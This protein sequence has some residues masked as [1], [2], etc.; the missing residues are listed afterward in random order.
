VITSNIVEKSE[1]AKFVSPVS[2]KNI[3]PFNWYSFKHRFGSGLVTE[4]F[5]LFNLQ[6]GNIIFDPFCGGGTTLIKAKL[7]GY[8]SVGLD[9]SPFSVFLTNILT[10]QY[11]KRRLEK[12]FERI[13]LD[14]RRSSSMPETQLLDKAF[15][16]QTIEYIFSLRESI[17]PLDSKEKN[18]FLFVLLS[19]LDDMSKAK[20]SGGFLRIT[21][22]KKVSKNSFKKAFIIKA[23]KLM[24]EV[25]TYEFDNVNAKA[26]RGDARRYPRIIRQNSY[27]AIVTSPPYPNRH[28]YTRIY[29]LELLVGFINN[30]DEMKQLRYKTLR[31]HV[32]AKKEFDAKGYVAPETLQ[33][34]ITHLKSK[35]L[36]NP[37]VL[38]TLTGYFEDMYLAIKAMN[39]V[40][41]PGGHVGLVVSNVRFAGIMV[42]VDTLLGEIGEQ[43]G[44]KLDC[45]YVLR[46]RGNSP[47]QMLE[48]NK[49]PARE[50]FIV[51]KKE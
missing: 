24:E 30:D 51:W 29:E 36:N 19:I 2:D 49:E 6:K 9:I 17:L 25:N 33:E 20:K 12:A 21:D 18:F 26:Y 10:T 7:D 22:K 46:Y 3:I 43:V 38:N 37:Q 4:M 8:H 34:I 11:K 16:E 5:Q 27:D 15:S 31:S 48:Y 44:L 35:E 45:I 13:Q 23:K 28:D 39:S 50:S 40:L 1:W 47:Q 41:K 14:C 32:E 42:P